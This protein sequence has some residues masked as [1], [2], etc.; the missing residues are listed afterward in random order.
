M[1][2][3]IIESKFCHLK[4]PKTPIQ[5]ATCLFSSFFSNDIYNICRPAFMR[6]K[7]H[8]NA[9]Y[10][11]DLIFHYLFLLRQFYRG[12]LLNAQMNDNPPKMVTVVVGM[13]F[14]IVRHI[15]SCGRCHSSILV[16]AVVV[17]LFEIFL[18]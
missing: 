11:G 12:L 13:S 16:S 17:I 18:L 10:N 4:T 2:I 9:Q 6:F 7:F 14:L 1:L 5:V 15:I 8:N 3:N